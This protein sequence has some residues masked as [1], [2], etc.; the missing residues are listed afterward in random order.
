MS[1]KTKGKKLIESLS[2]NQLADFFTSDNFLTR[3]RAAASKSRRM[4]RETDF[5][6]S[7]NLRNNRYFV[8]SIKTGTYWNMR[9]ETEEARTSDVSGYNLNFMHL[10]FHTN[11][12]GPI[13]PSYCLEDDEGDL[14]LTRPEHEN[15]VITTKNELTGIVYRKRPIEVIGKVRRDWSIDALVYQET[16]TFTRSDIDKTGS[17]L[18]I[19]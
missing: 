19:Y 5:I 3:L 6:A 10:H 13:F 7:V 9:G 12:K 11:L 14:F 8:S 1:Q 16:P 4:S 15:L 2:S 18:A 17:L